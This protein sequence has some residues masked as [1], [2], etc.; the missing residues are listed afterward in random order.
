MAGEPRGWTI[1]FISAG[2]GKDYGGGGIGIRSRWVHRV[3]QGVGNGD[4]R[5]REE[6]EQRQRNR[7][8]QNVLGGME[9]R[10]GASCLFEG[11]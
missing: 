3:L 8:M 6:W 2:R 5:Q 10:T 1:H 4:Y 9:V 11:K 7:N